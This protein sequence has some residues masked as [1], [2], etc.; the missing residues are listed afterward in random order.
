MNEHWRL[1]ASWGKYFQYTNQVVRENV[2]EG[3]RDFW[4]LADDEKVPVKSA[5]HYIAG[6]SYEDPS[7]LVDL[8]LFYKP[9]KGLSEYVLREN[10]GLR[11]TSSVP[12]Y[13]FTGSGNARGLEI[14]LQKKYGHYTGWISYTYSRVTHRFEDLND[15]EP[16]PAINDQPH[17]LNIVNTYQIRN[18]VFGATFVYNTGKTYTA[19]V[20][21]YQL[22]M[23]DGSVLDYT[24]VSAKNAFR[25]PAYHRLDVSATY[26]I[27][28][29]K[30]LG[31][32]GISLFNVY[33][34]ENVWYREFDVEDNDIIIMDVNTL[35]FTP[36]LFM[37][38]KF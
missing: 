37:S 28:V 32:V 11:G 8:E 23:L 15:G 9:M 25:L 7:F 2:L 35:G 5:F 1:K 4:M 3:N 14:L 21:S 38:V 12:D 29:G 36:N 33:G 34:R 10:I 24:H 30:I 26:R 13:F 18:F 31:S 17:E 27:S 22:T 16:Y 6:A 19:P 20:G